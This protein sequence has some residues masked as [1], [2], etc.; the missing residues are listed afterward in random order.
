[1]VPDKDLVKMSTEL[2]KFLSSFCVKYDQHPMNVSGIVLARL[3]HLNNVANTN[4]KFAE[5]MIEIGTDIVSGK[6]DIDFNQT[7]Q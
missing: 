6:Y 3:L 2:D 5:L 1:M 4:K 7:M